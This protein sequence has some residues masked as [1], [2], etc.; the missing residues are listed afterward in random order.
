MATRR[1]VTDDMSGHCRFGTEEH[2]HARCRVE[3][4]TPSA[5]VRCACPCHRANGQVTMVPKG[6]RVMVAK[7]EVARKIVAKK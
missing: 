6:E 4:D 3:W 5:T 1:V 2:H 7:G